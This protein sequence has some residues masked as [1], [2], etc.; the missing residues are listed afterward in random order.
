MAVDVYIARHGQNE[1]NARGI[2]SGNRN[3][4]LTDLGRLQA[5]HLAAGIRSAG[6]IFNAIYSSPSPCAL[7]TAEAV[8][9]ENEISEGPIVIPELIERDFGVMTG[10]PIESIETECAPDILKT[11]TVTYFLCP[12]GAETFPQLIKRGRKVLD[13]VGSL[14]Q[15]GRALLVCHGDLGKMIYVAATG[16]DWKNVLADFHFGNGDLIEVGPHSKAHKVKMPQ[17]NL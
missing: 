4:P 12:E 8:S 1:D 14:Q 2:L 15:N 17:H 16:K 10:K 11:D 7:E 13:I 3:L 6:I 9:E 5:R